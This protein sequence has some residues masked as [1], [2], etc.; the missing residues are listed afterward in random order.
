MEIP[1]CQ[2]DG[3]LSSAYLD[4]PPSCLPSTARLSATRKLFGE[5][6]LD[7]LVLSQACVKVRSI[8]RF[9]KYITNTIPLAPQLA[10]PSPPPRIPENLTGGSIDRKS[11]E[12]Y[13]VG[14]RQNVV[15]ANS[16]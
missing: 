7:F 5:P 9:T 15:S 16:R 6:L 4:L 14:I 13:Q 2:Q 12:E 1:R 3:F 10:L 8:D 11:I